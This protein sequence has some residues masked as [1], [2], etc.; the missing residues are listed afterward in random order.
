VWLLIA[1]NWF[2]AGEWMNSERFVNK[3]GFLMHHLQ[4]QK[5]L[6]QK[7]QSLNALLLDANRKYNLAA[8]KYYH[9]SNFEGVP[10]EDVEECLR[11]AITC[12]ILSPAGSQK[13]KIIN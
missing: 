4:D 2:H 1:A 12:A 7:Y 9:L 3:V 6:Q 5:E 13:F 10:S 11:N 8:W